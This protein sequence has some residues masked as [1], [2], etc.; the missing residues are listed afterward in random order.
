[1]ETPAPVSPRR[2][3]A[4]RLASVLVGAE[5]V[6][7]AGF[8]V[9]YAYELL[10]GQGSDPVV[11]VMSIVTMLVFVVGLGYVSVGLRIRHPR[12]QAPAMAFNGLMIPLG[13]AMFQFA[14]WWLAGGVSAVGIVVIAATISMGRLDERP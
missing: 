1:V 6:V 9:F 3:A 11:V 5:A 7:I 4:G 8:A 2:H 14:P 10:I 12:A 13:F